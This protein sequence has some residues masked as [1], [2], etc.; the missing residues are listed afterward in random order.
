MPYGLKY[1][2]EFNTISSQNLTFRLEIS[3]KNY[4]GD[5]QEITLTA[6]G[7]V[8]EWQEDDPFAPIKGCTLNIGIVND[9]TISLDDFYSEDDDEYYV[10]LIRTDTMLTLFR[11][12]ILQDDSQD[13]VV[14]YA[15]ELNIVATDNLGTLKD[16]L[17][18][19]AAAKFGGTTTFTNIDI[20]TNGQAFVTDRPELSGL[21]PGQEFSIDSSLYIGNYTCIG[22]TYDNVSS[23]WYINVGQDLPAFGNL[24][25]DII[26]KTPV[27]INE[28]VNLLT[29]VRL[30]LKSTNVTCGLKVGSKIYPEGGSIER[31]LDSTLVY[32]GTFLTD[33][34]SD[35]CYD[36]LEKI[37]S[38][39]NATLFQTWG[40]W[41]I[42]R[43]GE[44]FAGFNREPNKYQIEGEQYTDNFAYLG[45]FTDNH[46]FNINAN[47]VETG[48]IKS[49]I[50]P[51][52]FVSETFNYVE[53]RGLVRN[54]N[55]SQVGNL[56]NQTVVGSNTVYSYD[57]DFFTDTASFFSSIEVTKNANDIEISR[58]L[59][60]DGNSYLTERGLAVMSDQVE[61]NAGAKV[62]IS[63]D[64]RVDDNTISPG[65]A[66]SYPT[67]FVCYDGTNQFYLQT[68]LTFSTSVT[69]IYKY[70]IPVP[71]DLENWHSLNI[72]FVIPF[73]CKFYFYF[74]HYNALITYDTFYRNI[75]FIAQGNYIENSKTIGQIHTATQTANIKNV[76][77]KNIGLDNAPSNIIKGAL[78]IDQLTA[79]GLQQLAGNWVLTCGELVNKNIT[80]QTTSTEEPFGFIYEG[81]QIY[82]NPG[83]EFIL[84]GFNEFLDRTWVVLD[85]YNFNGLNYI[86]VEGVEFGTASG[87]LTGTIEYN[88]PD[89]VFTSFGEL[90]VKEHLFNFQKPRYKYNG[91]LL[92]INRDERTISNLSLF[93][94]IPAAYNNDN[95]M[96][97][98]SIAIDYR[99]EIANLTMWALFEQL[100]DP[101]CDFAN[102]SN[103]RIYN[104]SYIYDIKQ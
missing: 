89:K 43:F 3:K 74:R 49:I 1:F 17:L 45:P 27:E 80:L 53:Q 41:H 4:T 98:G 56:N 58:Y 26:I 39:F 96:P 86:Y 14:D 42:V 9:G 81:C 94:F 85:A 97:V 31:W 46:L 99:N 2:S 76:L 75:Q 100:P 90:S 18:I 66:G 93:N 48:L 32:G 88:E 16:V 79:N 102:F 82:F 33:N 87:T 24:T 63:Y 83:D 104:F 92:F 84:S 6:N 77:E 15:H 13:I 36:V 23:L 72:E 95:I 29:L 73:D 55:L 59:K 11:G 30:C 25:S 65:Y 21:K 28:H 35:N 70:N 54:T 20:N 37:M 52:K 68:D 34:S 22:L 62:T 91:A 50:R 69:N 38:R 60:I 57:A 12:Y 47:E 61:I 40:Q 7:C 8:Q 64:L 51:Y 78:F 67:Y 19:D 5:D 103:S 10:E 101:W 71:G 44:L